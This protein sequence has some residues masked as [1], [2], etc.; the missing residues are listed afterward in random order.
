MI[1]VEAAPVDG[2]YE[3]YAGEEYA[4]PNTVAI[5]TGQQAGLFGGPLFTLLKAIT[6]IQLARKAS[7]CHQ[8]DVVPEVPEELV[9]AYGGILAALYTGAESGRLPLV[10]LIARAVFLDECGNRVPAVHWSGP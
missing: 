7:A 2:G 6:A 3:A 1:A 4:D 8:L 5:V 10:A 9:E